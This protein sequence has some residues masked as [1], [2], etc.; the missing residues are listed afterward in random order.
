[1]DQAS[2]ATRRFE[3][4]DRENDWYTGFRYSHAVSLGYEEGVTRRVA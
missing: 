3:V 2:A 1:M 4:W